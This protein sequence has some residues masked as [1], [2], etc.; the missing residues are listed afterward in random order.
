MMNALL[1][2]ENVLALVMR[3]IKISLFITAL[4]GLGEVCAVG[5]ESL[6]TSQNQAQTNAQ[7]LLAMGTALNP[8]QQGQ[9]AKK[10]DYISLVEL[11]AFYKLKAEPNEQGPHRFSNGEVDLAI[12]EDRQ[13][14]YIRN[15][16][17]VLLRPL[18][19]DGNNQ[20]CVSMLDW[21]NLIDPILRP[22]YIEKRLKISRIVL[23]PACGGYE[24]GVLFT[25]AY[26]ESQYTLV[27]AHRL[28]DLLRQMGYEVVLTRGKNQ[29]VSPQQRVDMANQ[30]E[31]SL[32]IRLQ[33][34]EGAAFMRGVE[35]YIQS[36]SETSLEDGADC[37]NEHNAALGMALQ[38]SIYSN[39]SAKD[40]GLRRVQ[41]SILSTLK[42]PAAI[43]SLGYVSNH[44]ESLLLMDKS[45]LDKLVYGIAGGISSFVEAMKPEHSLYDEAINVNRYGLPQLEKKMLAEDGSAL[46]E[47]I[48]AITCAKDS[49]KEK[50]EEARRIED[51]AKAHAAV[52]LEELS[53]EDE[54]AEVPED[55]YA[56]EVPEDEMA[57]EVPED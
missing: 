5:S 30:V 21:S 12:G 13:S 42:R 35:S 16:R 24:S 7:T 4:F 26:P 39:S 31:D 2:N 3:S 57:E 33:L 29:F 27:V 14:L 43:V 47:V 23:D 28:A 41:Y 49:A 40:G 1:Y 50:G 15:H 36:P 20:L 22:L 46:E 11:A 38:S 19:L 25:N 56:E 55:E 32:Y 17:C 37:W 54:Y 53:A 8:A 44:E 9:I 51:E 52:L 18:F 34:N 45:Y 48:K 6:A 10:K